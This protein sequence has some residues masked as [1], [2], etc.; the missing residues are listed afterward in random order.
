MST[1]NSGTTMTIPTPRATLDELESTDFGLTDRDQVIKPIIKQ[2]YLKWLNGL[3]TDQGKMAIGMHIEAGIHP[4]IDETLQGIGMEQYVVQFRTPDKDGKTEKAC[5]K[6]SPCSLIVVT[7]GILSPFQM[8]DTCERLG[9]VYALE[10][11]RDPK[12]GNVLRYPDGN[13]NIKKHAVLKLRACV[14]ELVQHGYREWLPMTL[15]GNIVECMLDALQRQ[16]VAL[17]TFEGYYGRKAPFYGFA[18]PLVPS[19]KARMV[20]PKDGQQSP[21]YPMLA[22][23]PETIDKAYLAAHLTPKALVEQIRDEWLPEA[24]VW[25][26]EESDAITQQTR[27]LLGQTAQKALA[28]PSDA[29]SS[30]VSANGAGGEQDAPVQSPQISWIKDH[31]CRGN[32]E[33]IQAICARFGVTTLEQLRMSHFRA[34]VSEGTSAR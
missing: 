28:A 17:D 25:S 6:V 21:I 5:W 20:G 23:V 19:P 11:E 14:H 10:V 3:P 4:L 9:M 7:Q 22:Q 13:Q 16:F 24:V 1:N 32:Q 33:A 31:F 30:A 15:S 27:Q 12:T 2:V 34:L 18:L 8:R 26:I 29:A